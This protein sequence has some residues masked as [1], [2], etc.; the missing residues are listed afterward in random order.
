MVFTTHLFVFYYLPLM[1]ALYYAVD[2]PRYRTGLLAI[3]S[4]VFYGWANPPWALLMFWSTIVDYICGYVLFKLSGLKADGPDLPIIPKEAPRTRGMKLT[5]AAS[6]L[7][8]LALLG[9]FK[10]YGFTVENINAAAAAL[11]LGEPWIPTLNVVLP[12]GISFY[13]FQSMSYAIDVYRGEARPMRN[14]FDFCCFEALFPQLVAGPIV[15]YADIAEQMRHRVHS[16]DKFSRGIAFFACGMAKKIL[17]ANPMGQIADSAFS[18][19]SLH[20]YDAWYGVIGYAFQIYFDFSGYSDM[21]VGLGLMLG[22]LFVKNFDDP[23]HADSVTDIWRRWHISLS[24]W[25]RDYLYIPLGGNRSG[26]FRTYA[27]LMVVMLLGGF[28]HGAS[29]NFII[30]GA[31]HGGMLAFERFQGK[32]SPYRRLPRVLRIAITFGIM[33]VSWVFFRAETL[34]QSV[35]YLKSMFGLASVEPGSD[36]LASLMY[37]PYHVAMFGC[38]AI[39]VWGLP[40]SWEFTRRLSPVRAATCLLLLSFS[41]LAMWT[42]SVNPF[43]YFQF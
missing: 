28:W 22:F 16:Y 7:S 3:G 27:N 19:G 34:T 21:A 40:Q 8:N 1:L 6:M 25:L 20:W 31:I 17:L 36:A 14:V 43:L 32:D 33:C 38:A 18:A 42:Q 5:L 15:R 24:T 9:F 41:V 26:S 2:H 11:G 13:T 10:Y 39:V 37:A 35:R 29:W 4:Y 12:V 23:Y 30:W